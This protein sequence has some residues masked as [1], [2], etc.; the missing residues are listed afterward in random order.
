[1]ILKFSTHLVLLLIATGMLLS[2]NPNHKHGINLQLFGVVVEVTV[3]TTDQDL[4]D[5]ALEAVKHDLK[6]ISEFTDAAKSQ[7]LLRVNS[8]L[9][10][11][12]WFS[13][14]PSLYGLIRQSRAYAKKSDGLFNPVALGAYRHAW[15][16]YR[17][18]PAPDL[19]AINRLLKQDLQ[20]TDIEIDGIRVRGLKSGLRLDFDLLSLGYAIDSQ[21]EHLVA[22]GINHASIRIGPLLRTLGEVPPAAALNNQHRSIVLRPGEALCH[23]SASDSLFPKIGRLDP[24]DAWPVKPVPTIVVVHH[25]ARTASVACAALSVISEDEWDTVVRTFELTYAWWRRGEGESI[26]PAMRLRLNRSKDSN[27]GKE[28]EN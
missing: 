12:E 26:T 8:L 10:S 24:R 25:N 2:C 16:F 15:G 23:Y 11:G 5:R 17:Q 7:P 28:T 19:K 3:Y 4:A 6:L 13:V 14:N 22:L 21:L 9:Q 18:T 20:M 1:M 27:A